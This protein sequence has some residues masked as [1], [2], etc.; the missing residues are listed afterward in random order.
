MRYWMRIWAIGERRGLEIEEEEYLS[1]VS[2]LRRIEVATDIEEKFDLVAE[3]FYEYE[4]ELLDLA[5]RESFSP[6]VDQV[7]MIGRF[8]AINRRAINMLGS[9]RLYIDQVKHDIVR[10][11]GRKEP[12]LQ[13][14]C[15]AFSVEY[16]RHWQYR[17]AEALRN[18]S[19]H[20]SLPVHV[21]SPSAQWEYMDA[22]ERRLRFWVVPKVIVK[23]LL[24]EGDFNARL[25]AELE[26]SIEEEWPLSPILRQYMESLGTVHELVRELLTEKIAEARSTLRSGVEKAKREVSE[27]T[28]A[29]VVV[30]LDAEGTPKDKEYFSEKRGRRLDYLLAKNRVFTNLS[31]RYVSGEHAGDAITPDK[32]RRD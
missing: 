9:A 13:R 15:E 27:D 25:R 12:E 16:D 6:S 30:A 31:R 21:M 2:S 20:R 22:I 29:L 18:H 11:T 8:Q 28:T 10:F 3:N 23:R 19:L 4:R 7:A 26:P 1:I 5:L 24:D 17:I 14:I 32:K